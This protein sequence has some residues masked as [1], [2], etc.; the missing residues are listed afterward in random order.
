MSQPSDSYDSTN[1]YAAPRPEA[2]IA[3]SQVDVQSDSQCAIQC[4][5]TLDDYLAGWMHLQTVLSPRWLR[6]LLFAGLLFGG[7]GVLLLISADGHR[8]SILGGVVTTVVAV[9]MVLFSGSARHKA[10]AR[11]ARRNM[12]RTLAPEDFD[13]IQVSLG[14]EG[15]DSRTSMLQ[16]LRY[17]HSIRRIDVTDDHLFVFASRATVVIIPRRCFLTQEAFERCV[18]IAKRY[19]A[20][21]NAPRRFDD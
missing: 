2:P 7:I 21:D 14:P 3:P 4:Q 20:A 1:P 6:G 17:W 8:V 11:A 5:L 16:I 15:I 9:V 12:K 19:V 18:A 13:P 10:N